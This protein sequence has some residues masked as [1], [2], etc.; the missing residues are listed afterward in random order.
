MSKKRKKYLICIIIIIILLLSLFFRIYDSRM[1][2]TGNE[3]KLVIKIVNTDG[4]KITYWGL[5]YK[6]IRYPSVS[7][8]EP[9]K[10]SRGVKMGSWFMKYKVPDNSSNLV[11][12][13]IF[14][15]TKTMF[16]FSCAEILDNFYEDEKY[17]YYY[18]CS[19]SKYVIVEYIDGS[20]ETVEEELEKEHINIKDLDE[21]KIEYIKYE[22]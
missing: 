5:G 18:N 8:N 6:I 10:S 2:R 17:E 13:K 12:K 16:N 19:K 9:Y 14:D 3:P 21:F 1:V 22:K 7:P 20:E 4:T 11:I 15:K